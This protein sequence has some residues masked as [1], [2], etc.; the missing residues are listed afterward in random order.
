[1]FAIILA[2]ALLT[3]AA[4]AQPMQR[5]GFVLVNGAAPDAAPRIYHSSVIDL[6]WEASYQGAL[7]A[8]AR[9]CAA[10]EARLASPAERSAFG[11]RGG[12]W[13]QTFATEDEAR[14]AMWAQ[15]LDGR[16]RSGGAAQVAE[17]ATY[18]PPVPAPVRMTEIA[19]PPPAP[20]REG[21]VLATPRYGP[22]PANPSE[23]GYAPAYVDPDPQLPQ[24]A[25][26]NS[27]VLAQSRAIEAR[28]DAALAAYLADQADWRAQVAEQQAA[29]ARA[30][31]DYAER[32]AFWQR[33]VEACRAGVRAA[34]GK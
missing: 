15:I 30:Q 28:N 8:N 4:Q 2:G 34:C 5:Y 7:A 18:A 14:Q 16:R 17:V 10:L 26:L 31:R 33:Q 21:Y 19:P 6:G 12:Y 9:F 32:V 29:Q 22:E 25:A 23:A 24:T 3:G 20:S 11:C 1:M 27:Q 13:L